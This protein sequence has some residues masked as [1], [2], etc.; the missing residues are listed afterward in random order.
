VG[1]WRNG[2]QY[3]TMKMIEGADAGLGCAHQNAHPQNIRGFILRVLQD[4]MFREATAKFEETFKHY[5]AG[6]RFRQFVDGL[7]ERNLRERI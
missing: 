4:S 1:I 3:L 2:D 5:D 6:Q 7:E